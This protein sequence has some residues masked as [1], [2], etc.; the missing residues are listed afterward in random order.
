MDFLSLI[1]TL[2]FM[3]VLYLLFAQKNLSE[4]RH[5]NDEEGCES[6]TR[7]SNSTT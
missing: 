3:N 4:A 6:E 2:G 7:Q 1:L 5:V